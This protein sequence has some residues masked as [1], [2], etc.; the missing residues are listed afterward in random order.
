MAAEL[1]DVDGRM[2]SQ[3][4]SQIEKLTAQRNALAGQMIALV[5]GAASVSSARWKISP[6]TCKRSVRIVA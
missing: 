1:G 4:E 6:P 5:N 2:F 3:L